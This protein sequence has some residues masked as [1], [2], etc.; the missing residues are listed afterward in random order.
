MGRWIREKL[1]EWLILV[2]GLAAIPVLIGIG[3]LFQSTTEPPKVVAAA[4]VKQD[5]TP[6]PMASPAAAATPN[7]KQTA[8]A[9][10]STGRARRCA[11]PVPA[12]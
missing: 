12:R 2:V 10:P 4:S 3:A 8:A 5:D 9:P 11:V 1:Q 7:T 6:K